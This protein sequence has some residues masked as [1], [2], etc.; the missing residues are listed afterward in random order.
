MPLQ[1]SLEESLILGGDGGVP[2][3]LV[4]QKI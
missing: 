4:R 1:F 2:K 3:S